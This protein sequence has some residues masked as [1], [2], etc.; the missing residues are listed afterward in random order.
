MK[1]SILSILLFFMSATVFAQGNY[2]EAYIITLQNDTVDG[3]V[4]F[5]TDENNSRQCYFKKTL[6]AT[7]VTQYAPGEIYGYRFV[8]EG[9]FYISKEVKVGTQTPALLFLEYLIKGNMNL[10]YLK[11]NTMEE[12][13]FFENEKGEMV[14]ITHDRDYKID[15]KRFH[16]IRYQG[17]MNYVFQ[18][19]PNA[20]KKIKRTQFRKEDFVDITKEYHAYTCS[21]G[22]E[23]I[24]FE[25]DIKKKYVKSKFSIVVGAD[26][27]TYRFV[28]FN[29]PSFVYFKTACLS[30][31]IGLRY[32]LQNDRISRYTD[33]FGI[34]SLSPIAGR[35][36]RDTTKNHLSHKSELDHSYKI[37]FKALKIDASLGIRFLPPSGK[38]RPTA[39]IAY[40]PS[41]IVKEDTRFNNSTQSLDFYLYT[42]HHGFYVG[43][44][45]YYFLNNS[46]KSLSLIFSHKRTTM[47]ILG[48]DGA[49]EHWG[50]ARKMQSTKLSLAYTF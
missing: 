40:S 28:S 6:S 47:N 11:S 10:F 41:F 42:T 26:Y 19:L 18:V 37:D 34:V 7:D 29:D 21:P 44:G 20:E 45:V 38:W 3:F 12:W 33:L 16:D 14:E 15:G 4:D 32:D 43:A 31:Q 36:S 5:S 35:A 1:Y 8:E 24:V 46:S 17:R 27:H 22:E 23:C 25:N 39:E 9:K 2:K 49:F 30:P 50:V 48:I 13:Y